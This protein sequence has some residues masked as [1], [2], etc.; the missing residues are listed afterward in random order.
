MVNHAT[1][2]HRWLLLALFIVALLAC[3]GGV[4]LGVLRAGRAVRPAELFRRHILDPIRHSV[5]RIRADQ[6]KDAFGYGYAFRFAI[7]RTDL[8]LILGSRP[9]QKVVRL[10]YR[11]KILSWDWKT[12]ERETGSGMGMPVYG[13]RQHVPAWFTPEQWPDPEAYA[14]F[15]RGEGAT[16]V[17]VLLY[18]EE[19]GEA[20]F[21][22]THDGR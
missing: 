13:L 9:F 1:R 7:S 20:Y 18:N 17:R 2:S 10:R 22:V 14:I 5:A 21:I 11:D 19:V 15:D 8:G 16:D 3:G 12:A 4:L 6:T